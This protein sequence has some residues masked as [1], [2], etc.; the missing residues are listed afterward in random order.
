MIK[1]LIKFILSISILLFSFWSI[2]G[3]I[4]DLLI[5][6]YQ[7]HFDTSINDHRYELNR[8]V[9]VVKGNQRI[10]FNL[11]FV[12]PTNFDNS[13]VKNV[14]IKVFNEILFPL[15]LLISLFI[16]I[17][18]NYK[19]FTLGILV[20]ILLLY[21]KVLIVVYDNYSYPDFILKDLSLLYYPVYLGNILITEIG[22][23]IN[24][25]LVALI[26]FSFNS[27]E[28]IKEFDNIDLGSK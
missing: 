1:F 3:N 13:T 14:E 25:L 9:E 5:S 23:A 10:K 17:Y 2:K 27:K 22:A 11:Y 12:D 4:S 15:T 6:R 21:F 19:R 26:W 7:S 20:M 24:I 28:I 16:S 18:F 8:M